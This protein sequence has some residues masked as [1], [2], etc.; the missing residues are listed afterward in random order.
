MAVSR[1]SYQTAFGSRFNEYLRLTDTSYSQAAER[2]GFTTTVICRWANGKAI[3]SVYTFARF[4]H[5]MKLDARSV[6]ALLGL[7]G[8]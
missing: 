1:D 5:A 4:C 2:S 6:M 3:P 7:G 8:R